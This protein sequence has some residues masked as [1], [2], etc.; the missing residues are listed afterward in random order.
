MIAPR[1]P[2]RHNR[3]TVEMGD[4]PAGGLS[5]CRCE[6]TVVR[7]R[8]VGSRRRFEQIILSRFANQESWWPAPTSKPTCQSPYRAKLSG[9][10]AFAYHFSCRNSRINFSGLRQLQGLAMASF[11]TKF[12]RWRQHQPEWIAGIVRLAHFCL[13]AFALQDYG[14]RR[15]LLDEFPEESGR[16]LNEDVAED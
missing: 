4:A 11:Y 5:A 9:Q 3:P 14:F 8:R 7:A 15:D 13:L 6:G 1:G 12:D 10:P 2:C 16:V